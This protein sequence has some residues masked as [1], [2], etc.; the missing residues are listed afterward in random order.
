MK[1]LLS[2]ILLLALVLVFFAAGCEF[3]ASTANIQNAALAKDQNGNQK[4]TQFAPTDTIY[5]VFDLR[6]APDSTTVKSVWS[7]V[8]VGTAAAPNTLIDQAEV[9]T[10]SG[11]I[12]FNLAP[13]GAW[14]PGRYQ[15]ELYLNDA[16]N[17]AFEYQVLGEVAQAPADKAPEAAAPAQEASSGA[18]PGRAVSSLQEV[19]SATVRIEATGTFVSPEDF[20][21]VTF[22]G[23]GT[24]F[25]IDPSGIAVTNNHVVTG[26]AFLRV[27]IEGETNPRNAR[28]LGVS[29]CSDLAVIDIDGDGFPYLEWYAGRPDVGL[30]MYLAGFPLAGNE[31][32]TL[33]RGII[34]KAEANGET[35]WSSVDWVLEYDATSNG[36]NSGGPVVTGDGKVLAVH[37]AGNR[38][39]RQA[40]GISGAIAQN[41]VAQLRSGQNAHSIGVNGQAFVNPDAGLAGIWVASVASGSP[42]DAAGIRGGDIITRL[43]GLQLGT[44]GTMADYCDILRSRN[45]QDTMSVQVLRF[46]TGEV[47]EGQLNGRELET[48]TLLSQAVSEEVPQGA[49]YG[50]YMTI[51]DSTGALSVSVP[52]SWNDVESFPWTINGVEVGA[53]LAA[54]PN[55]DSFFGTW[56]TPGMIFGASS[57]LDKNEQGMLDQVNYSDS[58]AY[59]G[60]SPY[61][62]PLYT[63]YYDV[64]ANCGNE[65]ATVIVLSATPQDKSFIVLVLVQA[66]TSADVEAL[67]NILNSFIVQ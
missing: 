8:D 27:Y 3:S 35:P 57:A 36:G 26:A 23:Q 24:G 44:D 67:D 6:N 49:S 39:A 37:Y 7:A 45:P 12:H 1:T 46:A 38:D 25:I 40:F 47:L 22:A 20:Q 52:T 5:L 54:A 28:I 19:R 58:C 55:L 16:L 53:Q 62:D 34:S 63:G 48:V 18:A 21:Q 14:P 56:N 17:G 51:N 13:S 59:N 64:W 30:D 11:Q 4:T 9:T 42:A 61:E 60:R 43:E 15:V 65:G 41:V 32:Y 33:N 66:L 31:E 10:G 50:E 29:E 2:K